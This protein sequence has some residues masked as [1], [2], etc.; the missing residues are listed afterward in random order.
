MRRRKRFLSDNYEL[1][2]DRDD[3]L[4]VP[5]RR[6]SDETCSISETMQ[7]LD[8]P[9]SMSFSRFPVPDGYTVPRGSHIASLDAGKLRFPLTLRRWKNGDRFM[10]FGMKGSRKVSDY[11][12]D[13]K[14]S[15]VDKENAWLLCCGDEI[16]WLVGER[17]SEKF[18]ITSDTAF[19]Y[20]II[21]EK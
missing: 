14:Y 18:R 6:N 12:S 3:L 4:L 5:L 8:Y 9:V 17:I 16:V 1:I 13:R 21:C 10:P 7:S 19:I 20:Q 15:L 11:F 2:R